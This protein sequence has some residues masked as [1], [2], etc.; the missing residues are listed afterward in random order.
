MCRSMDG[1]AAVAVHVGVRAGISRLFMMFPHLAM[2]WLS[3]GYDVLGGAGK[4]LAIAKKEEMF[5]VAI[6]PFKT[7]IRGHLEGLRFEKMGD[8]AISA[9]KCRKKGWLEQLQVDVKFGKI[10]VLL[11][12]PESMATKKVQGTLCV[13]D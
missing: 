9:R 4:M 11:T 8:R 5:C 2:E 3:M 12:C 7:L 13:E 6:V 10:E 1:S